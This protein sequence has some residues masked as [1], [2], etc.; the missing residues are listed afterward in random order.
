VTDTSP[1][2]F[3]YRLECSP[4]HAFE[5][6]ADRIGE[7][8][9]PRYTASAETY[10]GVTIE[11]R[12]GGRIFEHHHDGAEYDWGRVMVWEPCSRLVHTFALAQDPAH[13][14]EVSVEFG[15][16]GDGCIVRFAHGGW[17]E[18]NVAERKKFGDWPVLLDRFAAVAE[19]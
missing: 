3:E 2:E 1:I 9:D 11:Q 6:Y 19:K 14:S 16:E 18:D 13:P 4:Q 15:P 7:W 5:T 12:E 17:T 10:D 8:W